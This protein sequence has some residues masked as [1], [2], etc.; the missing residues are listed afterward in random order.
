MRFSM[1]RSAVIAVILML[2]AVFGAQAQTVD[3]PSI[4]V[5]GLI[6]SDLDA[7]GEAG[8]VLRLNQTWRVQVGV[9]NP[10]GTLVRVWFIPFIENYDRS[11]GVEY[12]GADA[13]R[14]SRVYLRELYLRG[15]CDRVEMDGVDIVVLHEQSGE[16]FEG[17]VLFQ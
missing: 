6:F 2:S 16:E 15:A 11:C 9:Q 17:R 3:A 10:D 1:L 7:L 4:E 12:Q 8:R 5:G 13:L 14:L